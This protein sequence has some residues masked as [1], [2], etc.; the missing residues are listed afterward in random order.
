MNFAVTRDFVRERFAYYAAQNLALGV[1]DSEYLP[2]VRQFLE[3]RPAI[4]RAHAAHWLGT[5]P[6]LRLQ[7]WSGGRSFTVDGHAVESGW[8]GYYFPGMSV[9]V[10]AT[11]AGDTRRSAL[12]C[13]RSAS[14]G[15]EVAYPDG[16]RHG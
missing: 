9:R 11:R 15:S 14:S 8:E 12:A 1:P 2:K 6:M 16:S 4:I 10:S 3:H 5:G 13:Q 7:V